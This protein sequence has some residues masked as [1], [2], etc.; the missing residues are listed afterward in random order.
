MRSLVLVLLAVAAC[1]WTDHPPR[2]TKPPP[3]ANCPLP[4]PPGNCTCT[5]TI[6]WACTTCP[7]GEG[8]GPVPCTAIGSGCQIETWE[9]GCDCGCVAPG[10]WACTGETVG[11]ICPQPPPHDAGVD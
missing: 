2:P 5:D 4:A 11:S 3:D 1:D 9:H 6:G 10:W 8:S 7:F